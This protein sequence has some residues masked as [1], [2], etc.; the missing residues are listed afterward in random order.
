MK[1]MQI[2]LIIGTRIKMIDTDNNEVNHPWLLAEDIA[3]K[4]QLAQQAS[5]NLVVFRYFS[6]ICL[7][8]T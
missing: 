7:S 4:E 5:I 3:L 6:C 8:Q 2:H 1:S